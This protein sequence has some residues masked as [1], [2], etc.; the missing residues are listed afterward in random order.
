MQAIIARC[1]SVVR[2]MKQLGSASCLTTVVRHLH[3]LLLRNHAW[4]AALVLCC[5]P[6]G[7]RVSVAHVGDS[8]CVLGDNGRAVALTRDHKATDPDEIKRVVRVSGDSLRLGS[9]C[10]LATAPPTHGAWALRAGMAVS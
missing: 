9:M 3:L 1:R 7:D 6:A 5:T 10:S 2:V 4:F 8:R